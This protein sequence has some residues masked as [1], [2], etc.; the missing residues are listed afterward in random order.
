LLAGLRRGYA[1][2]IWSNYLVV[3]FSIFCFGLVSQ[4]HLVASVLC[5]WWCGVEVLLIIWW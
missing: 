3:L 1:I 2:L 5:L 4:R